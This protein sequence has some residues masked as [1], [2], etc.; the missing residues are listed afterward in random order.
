MD[1]WRLP[2]V[3]HRN[4]SRLLLTGLFHWCC[5]NAVKQGQPLKHTRDREIAYLR[6]RI[7]RQDPPCVAAMALLPHPV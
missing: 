4:L 7:L 6:L 2:A 3:L 5:S 1:A